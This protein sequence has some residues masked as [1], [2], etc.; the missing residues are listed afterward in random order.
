MTNLSPGKTQ[1]RDRLI[2]AAIEVFAAE[3]ITGATTRE[4]ARVAEVS[5]V[6]LF[7]HFP[8]KEQLLA[9]VAEQIKTLEIQ[10]LSQQ[11]EWT[12]DLWRDLLHYA[13]LYDQMIEKYE[14]L[15]RMFIGE[16]KRHPQ[17]ALQ[18]FQQSILPLREKLIKYLQNGIERG[19]VRSDLEC[20]LAV[21]QFTGMLL[22]GMLRRH[23]SSIPR[24]YTPE[25]YLEA[26]VELFV[27]NIQ[28]SVSSNSL[29]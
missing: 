17:E 21:D 23:V 16:A 26:C 19:T 3:G 1:T 4:I 13:Q 7:R 20:P 2:K 8:S 9:T 6:T 5:E 14:A 25:H 18:V 12:Q 29:S 24:D 28:A 10:A 15:I 22:A 27:R 11:E